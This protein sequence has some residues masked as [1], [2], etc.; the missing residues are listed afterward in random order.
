MAPLPRSLTQDAIGS[1]LLRF[2][3]PMLGGY[4]L[5]SLNGSINAIWIGRYLGETALAAATHANNLVFA[6][7][8][9]LFGVSQ[10]CNLL[11]AQAVGARQPQL[12]REVTGTGA[13]LFLLGA[14]LICACAWPLSPWLLR[15]MGADPAVAL[16]AGRYLQVMFLALPPLLLLIYVSAV[17]RGAGDTRT[18]FAFLMGVALLD[19]LLNP[20]LIFG[21]GPLP[22]FGMTGSALASLLANSCGLLALLAWLH[23]QRHPLWLGRG[24]ARLLRPLCPIV[25]ALLSKGLPMGLQMLLTSLSLVLMLALVNTQGIQAASAYSAAM[26]LW[27]YVQMP[28]VAVASACTTIAAQNVGAGRW[29]RVAHTARAGVAC[30]LLLTGCCVAL[31]LTF[32]RPMLALF[33]PEASPALEPARHLNRLVLV[34]LVLLGI[35]NVLAGVVRSTGAVLVPLLILAITLLGLRL[36]LAWGLQA[37]WGQD[38]LWWS[39]PLSA[40][41]SVLLSLAYY[42]WGRWRQ[43]RLLDS[44]ACSPWQAEP[45]G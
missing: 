33:L 21:L 18:P 20:L 35:S 30:H 22:G 39:F 32:D 19:C 15:S 6:L 24:D 41:V 11:V 4:V 16:L 3:L 1:T 13:S 12:A 26:Q 17:L 40:L 44:V 8:A 29:P 23:H 45:R 25:S 14:L 7:I 9:L 36:P 5:Q 2:A 42:R 10:A 38:A 28:A 31:L 37:H 34:S 43:A 27:A